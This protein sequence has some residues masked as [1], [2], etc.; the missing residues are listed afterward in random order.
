M[1]V[2][3]AGSL[4]SLFGH[5]LIGIPLLFIGIFYSSELSKELKSRPGPAEPEEKKAMFRI[6]AIGFSVIYVAFVAWLFPI[7]TPVAW[8]LFGV[9]T[10]AI[11]IAIY[12]CWASLFSDT[13]TQEEKEPI[14]PTETTRGK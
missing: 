11:P 12:A 14:Q 10:F 13:P 3:C 4:S 5:Y 6:D 9:A 1:V 7:R 8:C 2:L